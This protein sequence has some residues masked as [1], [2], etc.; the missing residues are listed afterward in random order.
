MVVQVLN[1]N[2][3]SRKERYVGFLDQKSFNS[4]FAT[5]SLEGVVDIGIG[6][7]EVRKY[8]RCAGRIF[9]PDKNK[10]R[11]FEECFPDCTA[12]L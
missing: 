2:T 12:H 9:Y 11:F 3:S 6:Y 7:L 1:W 4:R 8:T 5:S 10:A